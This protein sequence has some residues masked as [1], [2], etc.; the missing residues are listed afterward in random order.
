MGERHAHGKGL[1]RWLSAQEMKQS[2]WSQCRT[3]WCRNLR[4]SLRK[5]RILLAA[6][7]ISHRLERCFFSATC[8]LK[9]RGRCNGCHQASCILMVDDFGAP[10]GVRPRKRF[11]TPYSC[12]PLIDNIALQQAATCQ[13]KLSRNPDC[14]LYRQFR[15]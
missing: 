15:F 6:D 14:P 11:V 2:I 13:C 5:K 10:V 4:V 8:C 7:K 9:P 1:F 3:R 12:L